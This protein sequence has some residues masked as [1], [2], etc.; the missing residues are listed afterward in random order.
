M[1]RSRPA[2]AIVGELRL[3]KQEC[4]RRK[5]VLERY[6]QKLHEKYLRKEIPYSRYIEVLYKKTDNRTI[7][8]W[9]EYYENYIK[10]CE[11]GIRKQKRKLLVRNIPIYFLAFIFLGFL[12]SSIFYIT[13][14]FIGFLV[15]EDIQT[16]TETLNLQFNQSSEFEWIPKNLGT[17]NSVKLSGSIEGKGNVKVYLDNLLILSNSEGNSNI[18][19]TGRI[20]EEINQNYSL[21]QYTL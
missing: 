1:G 18:G 7:H 6:L 11:E 21:F 13:P 8:E 5:Q 9:I 2:I 19:I 3:R 17:L 12:I 4:D 14:T 10:Y 16:F 20:I 15:Q